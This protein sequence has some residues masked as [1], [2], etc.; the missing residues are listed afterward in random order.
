MTNVF[1]A[2]LT[3]FVVVLV[4]TEGTRFCN[5]SFAARRTAWGVVG[6]LLVM[7][8]LGLG[9]FAVLTLLG[10]EAP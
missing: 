4:A 10:V 2:A 5:R 1:L 9:S 7:L 6:M 8:D 3:A